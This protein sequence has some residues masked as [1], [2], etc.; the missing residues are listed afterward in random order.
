MIRQTNALEVVLMNLKDENENYINER[1]RLNEEKERL[2]NEE[3]QGEEF[4]R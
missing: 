3:S 1:Q 4:N 2:L